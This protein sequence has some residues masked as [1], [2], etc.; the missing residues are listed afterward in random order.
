MI[1]SFDDIISFASQYFTLRV[2]DLIFT[3]TPQGVG[4]VMENDFLEAYLE[5]QKMF[6]LKIQ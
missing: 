4:K 1:F 2:G 5:N 3:G 6:G